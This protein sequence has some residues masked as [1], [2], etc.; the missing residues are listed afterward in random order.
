MLITDENPQITPEQ[1]LI[2]AH[3]GELRNVIYKEL[4]LPVEINRQEQIALA[5]RNYLYMEGKQYLAPIMGGTGGRTVDWKPVSID[6]KNGKKKV[7]SSVY[8]IIYAD[9]IKFVA[10]VGQRAPNVKAVPLDP[11]APASVSAATD[12]D[13]ARLYLHQHWNIRR[14]MK[15]IGAYLWSTGPVFLKTQYVADAQR[16]GTVQIPRIETKP[17]VIR[18]AGMEC[19]TCGMVAVQMECPQCGAP[20]NPFSYQDEITVEVPFENGVEVFPKGSV[21]LYLK[22]VF[23]VGVPF[24]EREL[25]HCAWLTEDQ[26]VPEWR[27]RAKYD[28]GEESIN[29]NENERGSVEDAQLAKE[30]IESP[31]GVSCVDRSTRTALE[32]HK[33]IRPD[34]YHA[35]SPNL[36]KQLQQQFPEGLR[37]TLVGTRVVE[38]KH[39]SMD[40][41]WAVCKTG[42]GPRITD[43]PLCNGI[44]PIQDDLNDFINMGRE[45]ILRAIPKTFIDGSLLDPQA[46]KDA[47]GIVGE[48]VRVKLGSNQSIGNMMGILPTAKMNEQMVPFGQFLREYSREIDGVQPAIYGGGQPAT[49]FRAENQ[50]KNQALMQ[51]QPPFEEM[52]EAV[53]VATKNGVKQLAKYGVG[54]IQVTSRDP[55]VPTRHL[56]LENLLVD[57]WEMEAEESVPQSIGEKQERI[58]ALSQENPDMAAALGFSHPMNVA[59]M[60]RIFGVEGLYNPAAMQL[61]KA[62][63]VIQTLLDEIPLDDF[64]PMTGQ[65]MRVPSQQPDPYEFKDAGFMAQVFHAWVLSDA[66]QQAAKFNPDGFENVKLF[67]QQLD[68]MAAP[69]PPPIDGAMP[70]PADDGGASAPPPPTGEGEPL[71]EAP[72]PPVE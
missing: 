6:E 41:V 56:Q 54:R 43:P 8:N 61:K 4:E 26:M 9:G 34:V 44:V 17:E 50:R 71:P 37:M 28:L 58:S 69:P 67:G 22:T 21:D 32:S 1:E 2:R 19:T 59:E 5:R 7:F 52:Q 48:V 42:T 14:R 55:M 35:F 29:W 53:R 62:L 27:L 70:Q 72:M 3:G 18:P 12:A 65:P 11:M 13:T 40:D 24:G 15:E 60:Q 25:Q 33:W 57:N 10:V 36:R 31:T 30:M 63:A 39:E 51:L 23:D 68:Q 46:L 47:E 38:M 20:M 64:D 45:T 66:G 49:T 16:F